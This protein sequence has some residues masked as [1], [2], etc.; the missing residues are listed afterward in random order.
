MLVRIQKLMSQSGIASRRKC[1]E[2]IKAGRVTVNGKKVTE[3]GSKANPES[4]QIELDGQPIIIQSKKIYLIL[5]KPIG[6]L[7]TI[8]DPQN[9][10]NIITLLEGLEQ[11]VFPVGR[12]DFKSEGL[13]IL[14]NDGDLSQRLTHPKHKIEKEYLIWCQG[15]VNKKD[16]QKL[17]HGIKL[18]GKLTL[19]AQVK[20]IDRHLNETLISL[21]IKEGRKRQI[22]RMMEIISHPVKRLVRVRIGPI[23]LGRLKPGHWRHLKPN[24]VSALLKKLSL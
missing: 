19:P 23:K 22:R 11:R 7:T 18:D 1:E 14:T 5:N 2:F 15:K 24:E 6:Y 3:L 17:A 10:P 16:E 21:T 9:R 4:D 20:I 12:L 8:S 13:L